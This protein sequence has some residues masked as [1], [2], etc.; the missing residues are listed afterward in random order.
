LAPGSHYL[1]SLFATPLPAQIRQWLLVSYGGNTR[2]L[3][4]P[5]DGAVPLASELRAAAQDEAERLYLLDE[6]H[7][8]VL[9]SKRSYALLERALDSLP[10]Q[11]CK[12]DNAAL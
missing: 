2:M 11:G 7:T 9:S 8:S 3:P 5:N 6:T 4:E 10:A 1:Q 12:P